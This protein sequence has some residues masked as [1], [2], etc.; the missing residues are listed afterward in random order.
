[1]SSVKSFNSLIENLD[2]ISGGSEEEDVETVESI[3]EMLCD[4][5]K[6]AV[7]RSDIVLGVET[8]SA[9]AVIN[10]KIA[11]LNVNVSIFT[12]FNRITSFLNITFH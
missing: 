2:D 9:H 3:D 6:E 11:A 7:E 10:S 5:E 1:L 4:D 12:D 8:V